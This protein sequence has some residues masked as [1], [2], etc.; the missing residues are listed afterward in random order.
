MQV[1][2]TKDKVYIHDLEEELAQVSSHQDEE[3]LVFL[4]DIERKLNNL[5]T[6]LLAEDRSNES[7]GNELVLYSVPSSLSIPQ[8][9]DSVRKAIIET[10]ARAQ[11][12]KEPPTTPLPSQDSML[13]DA[14]NDGFNSMREYQA[15]S[16]DI[17]EDAMELG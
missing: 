4:P 7:A 3:R 11:G 13:H 15:N 5:P 12:H 6:R 16:G 14:S 2:D 1:E 8:D 17:D 9:Q 10:R